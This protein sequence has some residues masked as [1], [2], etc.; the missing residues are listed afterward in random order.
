MWPPWCGMIKSGGRA[1]GFGENPDCPGSAT[2]QAASSSE[3]RA[4]PWVKEAR[5]VGLVLR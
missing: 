5:A 2:F 3:P 1:I 4:L